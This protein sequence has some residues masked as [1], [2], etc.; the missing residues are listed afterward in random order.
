MEETEKKPTTLEKNFLN[1]AYNEFY[2]LFEEIFSKDFENLTPEVRLSKII[3]GFS[4]YSEIIKYEPIKHYL[5]VLKFTRPHFESELAGDFLKFIRH[6]LTHFPFFKSWGEVYLTENLV[7]WIPNKHSHIDNFL[8]K[9][10]GKGDIGYR[11]WDEDKKKMTYVKI[12]FLVEY[13]E[14][15]K[16]YLKDI[17]SELEGIRFC[18]ILMNKVLESQLEEKISNKNFVIMA[19]VGN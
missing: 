4:I 8:K 17:I 15:I 2:D 19:R 12:N 18:F 14:D 7:K 3:K 1:M 13:K 9:Y 5:K 16:L 10:C 11:F 6:V